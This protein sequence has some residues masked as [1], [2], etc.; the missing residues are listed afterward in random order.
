MFG[1]G[2]PKRGLKSVTPKLPAVSVEAAAVTDST[3]FTPVSPC[4]SG[5]R[6]NRPAA[7]KFVPPQTV[8]TDV[9]PLVPA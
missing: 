7:L 3:D 6:M 5:R 8:S 9:L 2:N 4:W 1:I